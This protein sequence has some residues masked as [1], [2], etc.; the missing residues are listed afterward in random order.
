MRFLTTLFIIYLSWQVL[1]FVFKLLFRYWLK[2]NQGKAFHYSG[3][4]GNQ[5]KAEQEGEIKVHTFTQP[6]DKKNLDDVG[7]YVDY[8]EIK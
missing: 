2:K 6:K 8:E 1:K 4:F 5:T 3:H 7:E